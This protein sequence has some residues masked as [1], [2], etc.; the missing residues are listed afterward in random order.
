MHTL[1]NSDFIV[2]LLLGVNMYVYTSRR[3]LKPLQDKE[4]RLLR[5]WERERESS[6]CGIETAEQRQER[7][8]K[9]R[10]IGLG[11]LPRL[12]MCI[13]ILLCIVHIYI[14]NMQ[15]IHNYHARYKYTIQV[16]HAHPTT[17][18]IMPTHVR[19]FFFVVVVVACTC[20]TKWWSCNQ[21]V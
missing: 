8:M 6:T 5:P 11:T 3:A 18:H 12:A 13:N 9:W 4:N 15:Y 19:S 10:E 20:A 1:L 21:Y 7:L 17:H 14:A 2:V 16:A